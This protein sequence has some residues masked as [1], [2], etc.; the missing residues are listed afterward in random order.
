VQR[1]RRTERGL[2]LAMLAA[3]SYM[4][5]RIAHVYGHHAHAATPHDPATA[6]RGESAY[7]FI[8]RSVAGQAREAWRFEA[9]RSAKHHGGTFT[10]SNRMLWYALVEGLIVIGAGSYGWPAL[11]FFLA[12]SAIAIFLL[13]MFN[14]IAHYGLVRAQR[15]DGRW[16]ALMPRHSWN[17]SRRMNNWALFNMGRHSDH[18]RAPRRAYQ[19]LRE[20]EDAHELPSG[21]AGAILLALIP[22]LWHRVMDPRTVPIAADC[23]TEP[24]FA[25]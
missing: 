17:S 23:K 24:A 6:R 7:A 2:G 3:M 18:H 11:L 12:Q 19:D 13:E 15:P 8:L 22:P 10:R 1:A 20:L 21:Y 14:Y 4:H 5:F 16:E 9:V 25:A